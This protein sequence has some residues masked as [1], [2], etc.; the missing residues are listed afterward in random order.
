MTF[1]RRALVAA[2][3]ATTVHV[4]ANAVVATIARALQLR[5]RK[6]DRLKCLSHVV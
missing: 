3:A 1:T 2:V 5:L 4:A 6:E